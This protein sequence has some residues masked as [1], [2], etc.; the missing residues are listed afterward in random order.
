VNVF[1]TGASGMLGANLCRLLVER[2]H[3]VRVWTRSPLRHPL[4]EGLAIEEARGDLLDEAALRA[5]M[6]GCTHVFHVAGLVSYRDR[7]RDELH[8]VNVL[9]TRSVLSAAVAAGVQRVVHTSSTAAVGISPWGGPPLDEE[10]HFL[11]AYQHIPYMASKRE[12]EDIALVEDRVEVVVV[13]PATIYG[14]GDVKLNTGT[15]FQQIA[16]GRLRFCPPGGT[17]VV[18][19][20]DCARGH[21]LAM[22]RGVPRR[23]Y[24]LVS[25]NYS[26]VELFGRIARC[27]GVR[28]PRF[29]LPRILYPLAYSA[30]SLLGVPR[31]VVRI[32]FSQRYFSAARAAR[33][34]GWQPT[35]GL[36]E[37]LEE[38]AAFYRQ[39]GYV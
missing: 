35:Q 4:L 2:G 20:R 23:R 11:P 10:A 29:V 7:D 37:M 25:G 6:P 39:Q 5:A 12:A 27:L 24:I 36:D 31:H 19:V 18:S 9:G 3:S 13:N 1:L 26:F 16:A 33:E 30:A 38:A 14:G 17:G 15:V 21:L 34:L 22:Q 32:G 8:R 28:P